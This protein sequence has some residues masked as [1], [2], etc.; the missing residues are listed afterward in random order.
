[1]KVSTHLSLPRSVLGHGDKR[2]QFPSLA[3][4]VLMFDNGEPPH[5]GTPRGGNSALQQASVPRN[6]S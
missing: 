2:M 3:R 5:Q 1:M 6:Q 4:F